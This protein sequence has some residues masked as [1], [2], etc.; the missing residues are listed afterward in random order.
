MIF[1]LTQIF[2]LTLFTNIILYFTIQCTSSCK[3]LFSQTNTV[4]VQKT[5]NLFGAHN[6]K[7]ANEITAVRLP[8]CTSMKPEIIQPVE[9]TRTKKEE[10][11]A[12]DIIDDWEPSIEDIKTVGAGGQKSCGINQK[13]LFKPP[14]PENSYTKKTMPLQSLKSVNKKVSNNNSSKK[15]GTKISEKEINTDCKRPQPSKFARTLREEEIARGER[16]TVSAKDEL[17]LEEIL[18][19][20]G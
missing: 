14:K 13:W 17:T 20:W 9:I 4:S 11:I 15:V 1:F 12:K 18:D 3:K 8:T 2:F 10:E 5:A 7:V 6:K 16:K 19:D